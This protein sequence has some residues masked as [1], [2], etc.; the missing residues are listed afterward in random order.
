MSNELW[1]TDL[2]LIKLTPEMLPGG[3]QKKPRKASV[4]AETRTCDLRN[5]RYEIQH[6]ELTCSVMLLLTEDWTATN[7]VGTTF[8][9]TIAVTCSSV[10]CNCA[11][12]NVV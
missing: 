2:G 6:F 7:Y 5:T 3:T 11:N 8:S 9:I 4:P 12:A 1:V 10:R